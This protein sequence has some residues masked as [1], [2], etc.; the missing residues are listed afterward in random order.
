MVL[1]PRL[2]K[3][4]DNISDSTKIYIGTYI[5]YVFLFSHPTFAIGNA[6]VD[7][8]SQYMYPLI[9]LLIFM[10][11]LIYFI[12]KPLT[13]FMQNRNKTII[14]QL[15]K[16]ENEHLKAKQEHVAITNSFSSLEDELKQIHYD[17]EKSNT[18]IINKRKK[19]LEI[20][21]EKIR[22]EGGSTI[23]REVEKTRQYL[24]K[25]LL[26]EVFAEV[27]N[28]LLSSKE[29]QIKI[30]DKAINEIVKTM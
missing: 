25:E 3:L 10:S 12:K 2:N 7:F 15:N 16:L 22:H 26:R 23:Q 24:K 18:A 13:I 11:L 27:N 19:N 29:D 8:V 21:C 20:L 1:L 30:A 6:K 5:F 9:N 17:L 4:S 14:N 28:K